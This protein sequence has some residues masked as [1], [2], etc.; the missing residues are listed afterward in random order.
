MGKVVKEV[1]KYLYEVTEGEQEFT[2]DGVYISA[3]TDFNRMA[4]P[5]VVLLQSLKDDSKGTGFYS[6]DGLSLKDLEEVITE[7]IY[8]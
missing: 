6:T 3:Y 5:R 1:F 2:V 4:E 7:K 8:S